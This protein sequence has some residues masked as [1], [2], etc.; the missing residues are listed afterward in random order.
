MHRSYL[1]RLMTG[2]SCIL[3]HLPCSI[4]GVWTGSQRAT[5]GGTIWRDMTVLGPALLH[6]NSFRFTSGLVSGLIHWRDSLQR[7]P[8]CLF[9]TS[10]SRLS[11]L[12]R[13]GGNDPFSSFINSQTDIHDMV[14]NCD[15]CAF[16]N[17]PI[18]IYFKS[19]KV[20][21]PPSSVEQN[22]DV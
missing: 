17:A 21:P 6:S 16:F 7:F 1:L 14:S 2:R 15:R 19:C 3:L 20:K 4:W 22:T 10:L 18:F 5:H 8:V 13:Q 11:C 9:P 12:S